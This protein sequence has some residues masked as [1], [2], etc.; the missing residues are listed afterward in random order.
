MRYEFKCGR[1]INTTTSMDPAK[2]YIVSNDGL[3]ILIHQGNYLVFEDKTIDDLFGK[4]LKLR[5]RKLKLK[6]QDKYLVYL[7]FS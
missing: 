6:K 5:F 2:D 1:I 3:F 4:Q 7:S